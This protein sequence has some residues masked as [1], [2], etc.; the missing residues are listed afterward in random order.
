MIVKDEAHVI[1]RCLR[2]A[3]PLFNRWCIVDT[4]STDDTKQIIA[5]VLKDVPG[6]LHERP[7]KN[8]G[9]NRSEG[10][11]LASKTAENL[12]FLDADEVVELPPGFTMPFLDQDAYEMQ[13]VYGAVEFWRL[14]IVSTKL[15]WRSVGVLHE[16]LAAERDYQKQRLFGPRVLAVGDGGRSQGISLHEKYKRDAGTL[17]KALQDE[18]ENSRYA[19]YLAQSYR[20]AEMFEQALRAYQRRATMGGWDEEVWYSLFQVAYLSERTGVVPS[21]ITQRY[22]AAFQFRPTRAEP[23]VELARYHRSR[24]EFALAHLYAQHAMGLLRPDDTLFLD[25]PCYTWRAKDEF[26]IA[27]YYLGQHKE[28][29]EVCED[30]LTSKD[31]PEAERPRVTENLRFATEALGQL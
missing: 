28:S 2:S 23:L 15:K 22:L 17:E 4:G 7:W 24:E 1:E 31:L 6:E 13:M 14:G 26:S 12:L 21:T 20:D 16:Y 27:A 11:D 29:K 25:V 5:E 3:M 10:I 18:P 9:H 19:F 8:F 30:L